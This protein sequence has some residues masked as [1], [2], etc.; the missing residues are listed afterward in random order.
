MNTLLLLG[1][2]VLLGCFVLGGILSIINRYSDRVDD[3]KKSFELGKIIH[4]R[5]NQFFDFIQQTV[6]RKTDNIPKEK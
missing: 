5:V 4:I 3:E 1:G 6:T 2:L